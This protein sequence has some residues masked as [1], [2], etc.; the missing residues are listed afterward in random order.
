MEHRLSIHTS[1]IGGNSKGNMEIWRPP[2][3]PSVDHHILAE[4]KEQQKQKKNNVSTIN[5]SFFIPLLIASFMNH[6]WS[7]QFHSVKTGERVLF[8]VQHRLSINL[9]NVFR[10]NNK[11][12]LEI[13]RHLLICTLISEKPTKRLCHAI[14][15]LF[16]KQKWVFS[17]IDFQK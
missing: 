6:W 1:R 16:K 2:M 17:S 4:K 15:C 5:L 13:W 11:E 7:L 12:N 3:F 10:N 8:F 14:S 9:H